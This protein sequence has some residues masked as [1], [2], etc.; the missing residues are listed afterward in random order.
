MKHFKFETYS[1]GNGAE[2]LSGMDVEIVSAKTLEEAKAI[3][4]KKI[5]CTDTYFDD[6]YYTTITEFS[7]PSREHSV[8]CVTQ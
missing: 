2:C 1:C 8:D 7:V 4:V 3:L 6:P 5:G